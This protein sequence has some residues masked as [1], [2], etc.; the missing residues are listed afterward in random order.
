MPQNRNAQIRYQAIDKCLRNR[1]KNWTWQGILEKVNIALQ[2]DNP[3]TNGIS[4][5]TL[6]EDLKDIEYRIYSGEIE[7]IK[8][9]KQIFLRYKDPGYSI[10]SQLLSQKETEMLKSAIDIITKFEGMPQFEWVHEI[11]PLLES[12][13]G[14]INNNEK[15]ISFETNSQ[16]AGLSFIPMLF[17]AIVNRKVI[18]ITYQ[19]FKTTQSYAVTLHPYHLRQYN[20]R[21]F[22]FGY[23]PNRP[24]TIQTYAIDRIKQVEGTDLLYEHAL[25]NWDKYFSDIIGVTKYD[26]EPVEIKFLILDAEQAAYIETKPLHW[27]QQKIRKVSEGYETSITVIPNYELEKLILSFGKRMKVISP[28]LIRSRI[29]EHINEL[30]LTYNKDKFKPIK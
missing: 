8:S 7:R 14:L 17:H 30:H 16:Y 10:N 18:L 25:I 4:K 3:D 13:F 5:T 24:E 6:Y 20:S 19:D 11:I 1:R 12:K 23:D 21:W 28:P 26:I 27:T 22:L 29:A 2:Q 9:G 15:I